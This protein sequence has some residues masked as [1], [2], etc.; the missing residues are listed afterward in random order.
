[1]ANPVTLENAKRIIFHGQRV[2]M[3]KELTGWVATGWEKGIPVARKRMT[4][5]GIENT[6]KSY[7]HYTM[8]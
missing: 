1:M 7:P 3:E 4:V 8:I 5:E 2:T 6:L